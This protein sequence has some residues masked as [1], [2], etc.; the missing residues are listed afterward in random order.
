[1]PVTAYPRS[2]G[3]NG[4]PDTYYVVDFPRR[5]SRVGSGTL[6][7]MLVIGWNGAEATYFVALDQIRVRG[8]EVVEF[9]GRCEE[10]VPHGL[11]FIQMHVLRAIKSRFAF[12][13]FLLGRLSLT[14]PIPPWNSLATHHPLPV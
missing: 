11:G 1:I 6:L 4:C 3:L 9:L 14:D 13:D 12:V 8:R 7:K 5:T 2:I 10:F